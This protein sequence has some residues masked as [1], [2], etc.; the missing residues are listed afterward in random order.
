MMP[1]GGSDQFSVF[2]QSQLS[3]CADFGKGSP[4]DPMDYDQVAAKFRE[5]AAYAHFP[6]AQAAS[7]ISMVRDLETLPSIDRL[8]AALTRPAA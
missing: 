8:M 5:N 6:A 7:V 4:A 3:G 1:H 2:S